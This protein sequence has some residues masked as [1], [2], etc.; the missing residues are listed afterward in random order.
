MRALRCRGVAVLVQRFRGAEISSFGVSLSKPTG[1]LLTSMAGPSE[2]S[3][4]FCFV[5]G[6]RT[7]FR[8]LR[9]GMLTSF[10]S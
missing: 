3:L 4:N 1:E 9:L 6:W 7:E 5:G 2:K 8:M 10:P